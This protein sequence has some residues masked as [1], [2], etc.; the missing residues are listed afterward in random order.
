MTQVRMQAR[1]IM[2]ICVVASIVLSARLPPCWSHIHD[3]ME[4]IRFTWWP[5]S[6]FIRCRRHPLIS[7]FV[8][9]APGSQL[10]ACLFRS[11]R[12]H[13]FIFHW[14]TPQLQLLIY[15]ANDSE[16]L[17]RV[18]NRERRRRG[19][20]LG[21]GRGDWRSVFVRVRARL[22]ACV[23]APNISS[24]NSFVLTLLHRT[25]WSTLAT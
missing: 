6:N 22:C 1:I 4:P 7:D 24:C 12:F 17:Q 11:I 18:E 3:G 5:N 13:L 21:G 9:C 2:G 16:S 25:G 10:S 14:L 20:G 19:W 8:L 15:S 23:A